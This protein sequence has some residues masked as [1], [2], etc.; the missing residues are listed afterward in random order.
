M[1]NFTCSSRIQGKKLLIVGKRISHISTNMLLIPFP[2]TK[3]SSFYSDNTFYSQGHI[4]AISH[5]A[6][7]TIGFM[8]D[9][10]PFLPEETLETIYTR[11]VEP[12]FCYCCSVW[13]CCDMTEVNQPQKIQNR[14]AL[15][16]TSNKLD[17]QNCL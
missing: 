3:I 5:K 2:P 1:G 4:K 8:R 17:S 6:P 16:L 9:F 15:I 10:K 14:K 7:K 13:G 12:Y 11:I